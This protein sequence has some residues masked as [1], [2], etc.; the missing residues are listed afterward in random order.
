MGQPCQPFA[1]ELYGRFLSGESVEQLSSELAIPAE[2]IERRIRAAV[3]YRA[4]Q[5]GTDPARLCRESVI[6]LSQRLQ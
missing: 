1:L 3:A 6:V 5:K 4:R 2:R